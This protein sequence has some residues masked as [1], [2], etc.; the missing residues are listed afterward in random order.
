M[1][2]S[3]L[4]AYEDAMFLGTLEASVTDSGIVLTGKVRLNRDNDFRISAAPMLRQFAIGLDDDEVS[5]FAADVFD[6]TLAHG[7]LGEAAHVRFFPASIAG[8]PTLGARTL[9]VA[10]ARR[11]ATR[12][13][14]RPDVW[15]P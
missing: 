2:P 8:E 14:Y 5:G 12:W 9:L 7:S 15:M 6:R 1:M 3:N 4:V 11:L 10:V 13:P